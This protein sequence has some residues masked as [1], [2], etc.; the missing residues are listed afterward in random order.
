MGL[1]PS[2]VQAVVGLPWYVVPWNLPQLVPSASQAVALSVFEHRLRVHTGDA[3][4]LAFARVQS[5][6]IL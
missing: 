5:A 4:Q 1:S 6:A 3:L 2:R